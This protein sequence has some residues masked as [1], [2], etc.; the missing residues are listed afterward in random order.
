MRRD[1]T[2]KILL[3]LTAALLLATIFTLAFVPFVDPPP[4]PWPV[5]CETGETHEKITLLELGRR[6]LLRL[7]W[8][9]N[10]L[11]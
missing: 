6:K 3:G 4:P 8:V 5:F 10:L 1:P 9:R 2:S 11:E 7:P